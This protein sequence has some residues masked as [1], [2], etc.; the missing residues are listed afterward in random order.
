MQKI[1][2]VNCE[3]YA[4]MSETNEKNG[5][6]SASIFD[7]CE[8]RGQQLA[9]IQTLIEMRE[10]E[11]RLFQKLQCH[12]CRARW[13][14]AGSSIEGW[15]FEVVDA[16]GDGD[17][18]CQS[19]FDSDVDFMIVRSGLVFDCIPRAADYL[20]SRCGGEGLDVPCFVMHTRDVEPGFCAL[21]TYESAKQFVEEKG[22]GPGLKLYPS[23]QLRQWSHGNA[24]RGATAGPARKLEETSLFREN[25]RAWCIAV[26]EWPA[27]ASD[28]LHRTRGGSGW[29]SAEVVEAVRRAGAHVVPR[30]IDKDTVDRVPCGDPE[31]YWRVSFSTAG[32]QLMKGLSDLQG[33]TFVVIKWLFKTRIA[34]LTEVLSSYH[35]KTLIFWMAETLPREMWTREKLR[36]LVELGFRILEAA[37]SNK[38]FGLYFNPDSNLLWRFVDRLDDLEVA[39][40]LLRSTRKQLD[41]ILASGVFERA[42]QTDSWVEN[43]TP[44][45]PSFLLEPIVVWLFEDGVHLARGRAINSI[46]DTFIEILRGERAPENELLINLVEYARGLYWLTVILVEDLQA[47]DKASS[48]DH[49]KRAIGSIAPTARKASLVLKTIYGFF[50]PWDGLS[51][52]FLDQPLQRPASDLMRLEPEEWRGLGFL[53]QVL[54]CD[55]TMCVAFMGAAC[56]LLPAAER[57][58]G[59]FLEDEVSSYA[60]HCLQV[61]P[62]LAA[63]QGCIKFR[64]SASRS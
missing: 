2:L 21:V 18:E 12:R 31:D 17:L 60:Y 23:S 13:I 5:L 44:L 22:K 36:A 43:S 41:G 9:K 52:Q 29:P 53:G 63:L 56:Q 16:D 11:E 57:C 7:A 25:D 51:Q 49:A 35:I 59:D 47:C 32:R 3:A 14:L 4:A 39:L 61:S 1:V 34:H 50:E 10:L 54:S 37:I 40:G 28:W 27:C 45:F 24:L 8:R 48:L 55:V 15:G 20:S 33:K 30:G 58:F 19:L 26:P 46:A 6:L 38:H 62:I 42:T 64:N